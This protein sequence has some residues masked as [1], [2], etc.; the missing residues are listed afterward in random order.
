MALSPAFTQLASDR[1][2]ELNAR[3][4]MAQSRSPSFDAAAFTAFL[5]AQADPLLNSVLAQNNAAG[6]TVM[7]AIFDA[8]ITLTEHSWTGQSPRAQIVRQLWSDVLPQ[9]APVIA[10]QPRSTIAALSNAAVKVSQ[11]TGLRA[12]QWVA[13]L[14]DFGG[15]IETLEDLRHLIVICSWRAG[16]AHLRDVALAAA[17]HL[18]PP[19]ACG[20]TGAGSEKDWADTAQ[21]FK[22]HTWWSPGTSHVYTQHRIGAFTGFDGDFAAPPKVTVIEDSFAV[23]DGA[24]SFSLHADCYGASLRPAEPDDASHQRHRGDCTKQRLKSGGVQADD[25]LVLVGL[26]L[27]GLCVMETSDSIAV[28]SPLSHVIEVFPKSLPKG[29]A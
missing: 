16:M 28:S 23:S 8:A 4:A 15:K 2:A 5:E 20:A 11:E 14:R 19:L 7:G 29:A 1:R 3:V 25:R 21:K 6:S 13:L 10:A 26:P 9:F 18:P 12:D 24:K 22:Q 17:A 27:A